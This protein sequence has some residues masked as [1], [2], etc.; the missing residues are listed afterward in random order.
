MGRSKEIISAKI[1][2]IADRP[3]SHFHSDIIP[4]QRS[5]QSRHSSMKDFHHGDSELKETPVLAQEMEEEK[6][7]ERMEKKRM[8]RRQKREKKKAKKKEEAKKEVDDTKKAK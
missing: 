8:K 4:T 7:K 6:K 1:V 3:G 2:S 5:V